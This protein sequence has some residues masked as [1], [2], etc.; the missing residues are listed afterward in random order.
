[1]EKIVKTVPDT[2][3]LP[4]AVHITDY[5]TK[6]AIPEFLKH[7]VVQKKYADFVVDA[8]RPQNQVI[9]DVQTIISRSIKWT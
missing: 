6:V 5:D 3:F 7:G 1:M 9:K 2:F 4:G 8:T